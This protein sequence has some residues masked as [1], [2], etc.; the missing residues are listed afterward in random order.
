M[1]TDATEA[2]GIDIDH[3]EAVS[4]SL[5][6]GGAAFLMI[7]YLMRS[8]SYYLSWFVYPYDPK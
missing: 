1:A 2:M 5:A 7:L 4:L 3:I 8:V 6:A